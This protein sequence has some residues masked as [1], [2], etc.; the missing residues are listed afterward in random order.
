MANFIIEPNRKDDSYVYGNNFLWEEN[1]IYVMSNHRIALWCWL[2]AKDIDSKEY[3]LFHIDEH[4]DNRLWEAPGEP[5]CLQEILLNSQTLKE[6]DNYEA[7]QCMCRNIGRET[8]PCITYDNFLSLSLHLNLFKFMYVYSQVIDRVS[9]DQKKNICIREEVSE[10][11][12]FSADIK[13]VNNNIIIDVDLDFFDKRFDFPDKISENELD[14]L[15]IKVFRV[16]V[17]NRAKISLITISINESPG[18][19][20]WDKRQHQLTIIKSI[21]DLKI[22]IPVME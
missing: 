11:D 19:P 14:E 6:L 10:I 22:P 9:E 1:G 5:E 7:Y 3:T 13:K 15:L 2:Q 20:L 17:D 12:L 8:R 16:I 4:M 21:L 18:D